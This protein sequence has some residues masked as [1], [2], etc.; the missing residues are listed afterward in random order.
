MDAEPPKIVEH[1]ETAPAGSPGVKMDDKLIDHSL[2]Q[3]QVPAASPNTLELSLC[4]SLPAQ[5][6]TIAA[7]LA[8]LLSRR[9]VGLIQGHESALQA[10]GVIAA[11]V[12]PENDRRRGMITLAA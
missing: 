1:L 10:I 4:Q 7:R 11:R 8:L 6:E 3:R 2:Q 12:G 9:C 5:A